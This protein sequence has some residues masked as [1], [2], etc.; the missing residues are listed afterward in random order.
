MTRVKNF[1][2]L[3]FAKEFEKEIL[4][5]A[6]SGKSDVEIAK[7]LSTVQTIRLKNN[8]MLKRSQSHP[9]HIKGYLTVSQVAKRIG[10]PV[11]W[12]YD[13]IHNGKI[14][15]LKN[16]NDNVY[17]LP[18]TEEI[19]SLLSDLKKAEFLEDS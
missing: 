9:K 10:V 4:S 14:K 16:S 8:K 5:L 15:V 2:D 6:D 11:H 1:K 3:P 12:V 18:D 19:T 7:C 17:M 13:R